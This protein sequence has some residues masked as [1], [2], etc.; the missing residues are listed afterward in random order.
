M[1]T[2]VKTKMENHTIREFW[3]GDERG[4]CLQITAATAV[5]DEGFVQMTME[6]AAALCSDLGAFIKREATRRQ[7]LL[8]DQLEQLK[9]DERTVFNEV[10]ELPDELMAGPELAVMMVSRFCP[11]TPNVELSG[12]PL[13]GR[14]TQTQG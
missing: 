11:K 12:D 7:R 13:A 9:R 2:E 8:R 1:G 3:G 10:A 6:E 14:P 5:D 4:V